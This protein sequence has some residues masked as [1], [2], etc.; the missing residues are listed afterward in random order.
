MRETPTVSV[1]ILDKDYQVACPDEE[2]AALQR[3]A[4]ELDKRMRAV[5]SGGSIV[6]LERIAVMVALNLCYE[7]QEAKKGSPDSDP[8]FLDRLYQKLDSALSE[9]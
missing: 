2:K 7:L 4:D 5:R 6:G 9:V 1:K 8:E 3:A